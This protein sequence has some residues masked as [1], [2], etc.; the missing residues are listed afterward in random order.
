MVAC[1]F[2]NVSV[3]THATQSLNVPS[4]GLARPLLGTVGRMLQNLVLAAVPQPV[5]L[6]EGGEVPCMR[7]ASLRCFLSLCRQL[8]TYTPVVV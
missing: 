7:A 4:T 8:S 3:L 2:P 1:S 6:P 5:H